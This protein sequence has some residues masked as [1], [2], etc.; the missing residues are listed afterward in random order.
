MI[1]LDLTLPEFAWLSGD[2]HDNREN[3]SLVYRELIIHTPT[4]GIV[5]ILIGDDYNV[6][7]NMAKYVFK[8]KVY[9]CAPCEYTAVL[10]NY[11]CDT[12]DDE[13]LLQDNIIIP[14]SKW[15]CGYW[16]RESMSIKRNGRRYN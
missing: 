13:K 14:A 15:F 12:P 11:R 8:G 5:E 10:L 1:K 7:G 6:P 4:A 9:G 2:E 3:T 16:D